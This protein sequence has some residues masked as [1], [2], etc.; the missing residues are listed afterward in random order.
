MPNQ[1]YNVANVL[2]SIQWYWAEC[3]YGKICYINLNIK[4]NHKTLK[5]A[6]K[7]IFSQ[8]WVVTVAFF[9]G[10]YTTVTCCPLNAYVCICFSKPSGLCVL[11]G[12]ILA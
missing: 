7:V 6:L 8:S 10:V 11:L 3:K 12:S 1:L 4:K 5:D 2:N 9:L